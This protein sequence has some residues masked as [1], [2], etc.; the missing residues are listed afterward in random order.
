M[1]YDPEASSLRVLGRGVLGTVRVPEEGQR[2]A[3]PA[4]GD[5][6]WW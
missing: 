1:V 3:G 4:T 5:L 6:G 2:K